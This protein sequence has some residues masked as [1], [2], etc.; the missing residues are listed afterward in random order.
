MNEIDGQL[1]ERVFPDGRCGEI[2]TAEVNGERVCR[3]CA[4]VAQAV[5]LDARAN[6]PNSDCP[7]SSPN[8]NYCEECG[9]R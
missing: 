3:H 8:E 5:R 1:C 2:A 4:L 9:P 6:L 7:L